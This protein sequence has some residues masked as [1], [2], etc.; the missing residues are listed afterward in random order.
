[1]EELAALQPQ[2]DALLAL[3]PAVAQFDR[4]VL[5]RWCDTVYHRELNAAVVSP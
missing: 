4:N 3:R 2:M 1:L 5:H